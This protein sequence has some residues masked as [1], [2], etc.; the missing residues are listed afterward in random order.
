MEITEKAHFEALYNK[1]L[2]WKSSQITQ[3]DGYVYEKSFVTFCEEFNKELF[4]LSVSVPDSKKKRVITRYGDI[5]VDSEHCMS[6]RGKKGFRVSPYLQELACYV[7]QQL[8]FDEA[9]DNLLRVGRISLTDKQIER[10]S[11]EYGES[12]ES[13]LYEDT[14]KETNDMLHYAMMDGSM[15]LTRKDGW[16]EVKLG[17]IFRE[18]D[19]LSIK[20]RGTIRESDYVAHLGNHEDFLVKFESRLCDKTNIVAIADGA[21][22]IWDFWQENYP[23]A[24]QILDFYHAIEKIGNWI[25]LAIKDEKKAKDLID[26]QE[27]YLLNDEID[28]VILAINSIE[29]K[30]YSKE[31]QQLLTYLNNNKHRMKYKTYQDKGLMIGSGPIEAANRQIIQAR[32]KKSGQRWTPKGLQQVD[33][34]RVAYHSD[35]WDLIINKI[36]RAA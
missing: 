11:H 2:A 7:G 10:I 6:P 33:N 5:L 27:K 23:K 35:R 36:N 25:K 13:L 14:I 32:L 17:R 18:K 4:E 16:K 21:R 28:E 30:S 12:L 29:S 24:T 19:L 8:S 1:Y 26:L 20:K 3:T 22:W 34:L 9:S 15:C 31:K